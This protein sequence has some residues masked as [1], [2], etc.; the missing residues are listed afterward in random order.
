MLFLVL[1]PEPRTF[2]VEASEWALGCG[3]FGVHV[4]ECGCRFEKGLIPACWKRVAAQ[5]LRAGRCS[6]PPS[7]GFASCS[8]GPSTPGLM[9][10]GSTGEGTD[11]DPAP[12][13]E[14]LAHEGGPALQRPSL[15][16][17]PPSLHLLELLCLCLSALSSAP[18]PS[19]P[20][21]ESFLSGGQSCGFPPSCRQVPA[22]SPWGVCRRQPVTDSHH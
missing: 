20:P 22:R 1:P 11:A 2:P 8:R 19:L 18:L 7:C 14:L 9:S 15:P 16:A 10:L 12:C 17:P 13:S 21:A 5:A 4:Q 6:L 3:W